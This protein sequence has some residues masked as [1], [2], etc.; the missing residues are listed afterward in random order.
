MTENID[1]EEMCKQAYFDVIYEKI[2]QKPPQYGILMNVFCDIK[3]IIKIL[4][5]GS[6]L[7]IE[8]EQKMDEKLFEQMINHDAFQ[9]KD[10]QNLVDYTFEKCMQLGSAAR[11]NDTCILRDEIYKSFENQLDFP[12]IILLYIK[13]IHLCIEWMLICIIF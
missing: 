11:D 10:F 2:S 3:H 9:Q 7:R 6:D 8:I 12:E 13:Y 1:L 4:K 5:V